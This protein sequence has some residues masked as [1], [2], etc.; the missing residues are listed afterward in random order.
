MHITINGKQLSV[1]DAL[2]D[3]VESTLVTATEKYFPQSIDA[4]VTLSPEGRRFAAD[5]IAHPARGLSING[6]GTGDTPEAAFDAAAGRIAKRLR[7]HKRRLVAHHQKPAEVA[8]E[9]VQHYVIDS[10][11]GAA[12]AADEAPDAPLVIAEMTMEIETLTVGE[13]V[14]RLDLGDLPALMFR[15]RAHRG[16]N[17]IYRRPDGNIGWM[18]PDGNSAAE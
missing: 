12:D 7:R 10:G 5:I 8:N 6:S 16:L 15:N 17:M 11:E 9:P 2:R 1:S 14:M 18:D 13:A 4:T 3:H